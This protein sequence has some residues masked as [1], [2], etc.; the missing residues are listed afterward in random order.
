MKRCPACWWVPAIT[1][2]AILWPLGGISRA[3]GDD[4]GEITADQVRDAIKRGVDYLKHTQNQNGTWPDYINNPGGVTSL[5]TLAL[6]TA[7]EP[8]DSEPM[9][10]A[11]QQVRGIQPEK[12]YVVSLQ[13]MVLCMAEPKKDLLLIRRNVQWLEE[14]QIKN[15]PADK[16]GTWS[17]TN[18]M[19]G[20][21]NSNTQFAMLALHEAE[22]VGVPVS[23]GIWRLALQHWTGDQ[24]GDGS[25]GY[26]PNQET[27]SMTCAGIASVVIASGRLSSGDANIAGGEL[28][29][30]GQHAED[31]AT[32]A[33][34]RGLAW[35][36][37]HFSVQANPG[38]PAGAWTMYYLYAIERVGRMT[39]NRFFFRRDG[40]RYDWY[41]MGA[42]ALLARQNKIGEG[43]WQGDDHI[44]SNPQISTS[45]ALMFLA[46]GRRPVL[47]SKAKYGPG[48]DWQT[49]HSDIANITTYVE[50]KWKKDFPLGLSWQVADVS[51]AS[52]ED[53]LQAPVLYISGSQTPDLMDQAHKLRDYVDRGGFILAEATCPYN[54][55]FDAG[56]RALMEKVFEEPEFRLKPLAPEHPLWN[57][58]EP[59]RPALRPNLWSVDYGCRTS[60]IYCA[61]PSRPICPT[62]CRAIGKSLPAAIASCRRKCRSSSMPRFQW[63]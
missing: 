1:I 25:W 34:A 21:D 58:E 44:E 22:R 54:G 47:V 57:A 52:V 26:F 35:L 12:T 41:R 4:A 50:T 10:R 27:G 9:Q 33:I 56:F 62:A 8:I 42:E 46:K 29:C 17:Y 31:K 13:T 18:E 53:L 43:Y 16:V 60:V 51:H 20:G 3:R 38:S 37:D 24:R 15:G 63:E 40:Q 59:V 2:V 48:D 61:R 14:A 23:Q 32:V 49:H 30:C 45:F 55:G 28:Q 39:S 5:C 19:R 6:L 11:L 7:G 36:G